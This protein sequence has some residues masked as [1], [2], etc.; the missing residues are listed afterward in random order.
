MG[1][2]TQYDEDSYRL[3]AG[4]VRTGYDADTGQYTF[5]DRTGTYKGLPGSQYS[6]VY[7]ASAPAPQHIPAVAAEPIVLDK[8]STRSENA[9]RRTTLPNVPSALRSLRRSLTTVR[10]PW[11]RDHSPCSDDEEPV[12]VSRPASS[13]SLPLQSEESASP[14][15]AVALWIASLP[16]TVSSRTSR[17]TEAR[18]PKLARLSPAP[19]STTSKPSKHTGNAPPTPG[20]S[21]SA[22]PAPPP[23]PVQSTS[24][25]V[26][27]ATIAKSK[28]TGKAPPTL[29]TGE[30]DTPPAPPPKPVQSTGNT[31]TTATVTRS[32]TNCSK[33]TTSPISM[34]PSRSAST[35]D[36]RNA[37]PGGHTRRSASEHVFVARA[38][39]SRRS[40]ATAPATASS[41]VPGAVKTQTIPSNRRRASEQ[42]SSSSGSARPLDTAS[43]RPR[44]STQLTRSLST[45]EA[46]RSSRTMAM[47][48]A[49]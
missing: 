10:N 32:A 18:S 7:P 15:T 13:T 22:T 34:A 42:T 37:L 16:A 2:W 19:A 48:L 23:K 24:S 17:S 46:S 49:T 3:P 1:R 6:P 5:R 45:T 26:S 41:V 27:T 21:E 31:A 28:H 25:T 29:G 20:A 35:S 38:P 4:M 44:T 11:R 33:A 43:P 14:G 8:P 36:T 47:A 40:I 12:I 30:S 9:K 39:T